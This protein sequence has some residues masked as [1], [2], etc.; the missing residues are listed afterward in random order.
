MVA[1]LRKYGKENIR[2]EV[3]SNFLSE[4]WDFRVLSTFL[5]AMRMVETRGS[6]AVTCVEYPPDRDRRQNNPFVC[7]RKVP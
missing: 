2:L 7:T 1:T 6:V 5:E 4:D 3:F